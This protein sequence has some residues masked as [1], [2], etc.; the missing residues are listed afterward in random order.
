MAKLESVHD[1]DDG[2]SIGIN[3]KKLKDGTLGAPRWYSRHYFEGQNGS[4]YISLRLEAEAGL[5]NFR[6][7][8]KRARENHRLQRIK[9]ESG[10]DQ[11]ATLNLRTIIARFTQ[12]WLSRA[13]ENERLI[14]QHA[15][16]GKTGRPLNLIEVDRGQGH[17]SHARY[18]ALQTCLSNLEAYWD[19]LP[20]DIITDIDPQDLDTFTDWAR[21]SFQW[22]PNRILRHITV[23]RQIWYYAYDQKLIKIVPAP[24][25]PKEDLKNRKRRCFTETEYKQL[26]DWAEKNYASIVVKEDGTWQERKDHAFQFLCWIQFAAFIGYRPPSGAVKKNLLRWSS[27]IEKDKGTDSEKRLFRRID[28]KNHDYEATVAK[29]VWPLFDALR[30]LYKKRGIADTEFIFAHTFENGMRWKAGD[31]LMNFDKIWHRA[32]DALQLSTDSQER[33]HRLTAYSLRSYHITMRI[34]YGNV[35]IYDLSKSLGTS[36]RMVQDAYDDYSTEA[37]YDVLTAGQSVDRDYTQNLD[38]NGNL[39]L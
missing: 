32:L 39:I 38:E 5:G 31:A 22:S 9:H 3:R 30:D 12:Q 18:K 1:L 21:R 20:T 36:M 24:K 10:I 17:Y 6:E 28:E 16:D 33:R 14:A 35:N 2:L 19:T 37:K 27:L 23:I 11:T 26:V 15:E 8:E 13:N 4:H 34:R 29:Q 25:R 7:A